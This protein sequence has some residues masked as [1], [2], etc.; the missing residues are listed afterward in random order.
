MVVLV[1]LLFFELVRAAT[2]TIAIS[3]ILHKGSLNTA[4]SSS[5]VPFTFSQHA[6]LELHIVETIKKGEVT[7]CEGGCVVGQIAARW[8]VIVSNYLQKTEADQ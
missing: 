7:S 8:K 1:T 4:F 3:L 5:D 6:I 2:I